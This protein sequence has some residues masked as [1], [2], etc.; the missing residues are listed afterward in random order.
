VG[1]VRFRT[2]VVLCVAAALALAIALGATS[3]CVNEAL[4]PSGYSSAASGEYYSWGEV[5]HDIEVRPL[6]PPAVIISPA[7]TFWLVIALAAGITGLV[8]VL[9]L[10][11]AGRT[12]G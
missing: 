11:R 12:G 1:D 6:V 7:F 3:M 2:R 9:V 8:L 4:R 5:R 10:S